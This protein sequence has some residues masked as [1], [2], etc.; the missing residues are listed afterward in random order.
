V[1]CEV[2]LDSWLIILGVKCNAA[3]KKTPM[4]VKNNKNARTFSILLLLI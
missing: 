4:H 1:S 2:D 3:E